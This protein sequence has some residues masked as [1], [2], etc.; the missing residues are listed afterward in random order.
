[1]LKKI[2]LYIFSLIIC[3]TTLRGDESKKLNMLLLIADDLNCDVGCY[4]AS[5]ISTPNIDRLSKR[6]LRFEN[7]YCQYPWCCPSRSSFMTGRRPNVTQVLANPTPDDPMG[8]YFRL[9]LPKTIT[10]PQ[11][12]KKNGYFSARVGKIYHYGVPADIGTSSLDDYWSWDQVVNPRGRD[13]E[14]QDKIF[15]LEPGQFGGTLSWLADSEGEDNDHSDGIGASEAIKFLEKFK[16]E[17]RP[18]FLGM[19]FYRPHTP[20][21]SPKHYFDLYPTDSISLPKLSDDDKSRNPAVAYASFHEVQDR[22]TDELRKQAIQGYHASTSFMDAQVGRVVDALDRLGLS[23]NTIIVFMSDHGYHLADHGLWQKQSLFNRGTRVP[24]IIVTPHSKVAGKVASSEI[25]LVDLYP[26]IASLCGLKAPPYLDGTDLSPVLNDPT[27]KLKKAAFS[28]LTR[29][30]GD[31]G[32]SVRSGKWRY[33]EW[34]SKKGLDLGKQLFDEESDPDETMNL[35]KDVSYKT[36]C[37][38][39]ASLI[40]P[41]R[42]QRPPQ[43]SSKKSQAKSIE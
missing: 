40:V 12:F 28:Q 27:L 4:G 25:E 17:N 42:N 14:E 31:E 18:F 19:G 1:M 13:R 16:K 21:V 24:F 7:A 33:T 43:V 5:N 15:T 8:H 37:D 30:N 9:T 3:I 34:R 6:G 32:Y 36:K 10:L 11:L 39:L 2:S 38:E 35:A 20:Y 23:E 22:M 41:I 29:A 26:T